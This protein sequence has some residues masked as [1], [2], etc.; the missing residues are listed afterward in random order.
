MATR[1]CLNMIV[2]DE[3]HCLTTVLTS[4]RPFIDRW[5]VVD[6][7]STD[8][9]QDLVRELLRD[10]PGELVERPWVDFAHNRNE[11]LDLARASE[12][13]E[14]GDYALFVDAD[15]RLRNLPPDL[16]LDADGYTLTIVQGPTRYHRV[17]IV[18]LDRPWRWQGVVHEALTLADATVAHLDRPDI[19]I[20]K[21]GSRNK[22]PEVYRRDAEL[23]E[24]SLSAHPDDPRSEFYLAQS[25]RD[26][27]DLEK[28]LTWY[29]R[30]L[31]DPVGWDQ[32]R[33]YSAYQI[34]VLLERLERPHERIA[35][36]YLEAFELRPTRAEPLVALARVERLRE[37]YEV[38]LLYVARA[39]EMPEP[40]PTDIFVDLD[41]Y[42]WKAWDEYAVSAYWAG[43]FASGERAARRALA[44]RPAD[45][46]LKTNLE[47]FQTRAGG[48]S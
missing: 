28:A 31:A 24:R 25:Y 17:A 4:V 37:H 20:G 30:R 46:R 42:R 47:F 3:A 2:K 1:I 29:R 40:P 26:S 44:A 39:V 43:Y 10:K 36:A 5:T 11:A 41:V 14:P 16:A 8:G 38:A 32:E 9:S 45:K 6:T 33:W 22:D 18:A 21:V 15:D 27:G 48:P 35:A 7:G 23:L 13:A 34:G 12:H 19:V